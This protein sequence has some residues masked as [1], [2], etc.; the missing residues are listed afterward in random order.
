[1]VKSEFLGK[2]SVHKL[3]LSL[4]AF[5]V[6][7]MLATGGQLV[8][9]TLIVSRGIDIYAVSAIGIL[10]PLSMV[11]FAFSQL[12]AIGA[13]SYISRKLGERKQE[14]IF[15]AT[16][17]AFLMTLLISIGLM[18]LT[19]LAR[20]Q[21]LSFLGAEG[22]ALTFAGTYLNALIFSIPFTAIV[23]LLSA[24]FR[25][26]GK[27][28]YSMLVIVVEAVLIVILDAV[29]VFFFGW[30]IGWIAASIAIASSVATLLG[31]WLFIKASSN[32]VVISRKTMKLDLAAV[33]GILAVGVSA[34]GRSLAT[35]AFALIL[36]RAVRATGQE[37]ALAA[38]GTVNRIAL[39]LTFTVMGV[40]Q[41]MQPV[42]S[43]NFTSKQNVRV[44]RALKYALIYATLVGLA[45]SVMGIF[46]SNH[47]AEIFTTN[48][49]VV[50]DVAIV[51]R[52]QM[53][54]FATIGVQT[55]AATYYQS[56]GK[57]KASFFLSVAKPVAIL[58]PLVY[59][60][61]KLMNDNLT[62]VW[63]AFPIA[64]VIF[65]GIC[66]IALVKGMKSLG[67]TTG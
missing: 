36:N 20:E 65:T 58:I 17:T 31:I 59:L 55:L 32:K 14:E 33:K 12:V 57:A 38:L 35:A 27:M 11:Y 51:F 16:V 60:L 28:K 7:G 1:M 61:P 15:P 67:S 48:Q 42:V 41:A 2:E 29:F 22:E 50:D 40:N 3:M 63:W 54:L 53:I 21:I 25:A 10:H 44:R 46:L 4:G 18:G 9:T 34:L 19:W 26:Y 39:F 8:L 37:D 56:I 49:D 45:G 6:I 64:D 47:V 62:A 13:A 52:K 5:A 24:I 66:V 30:G 43:F 23:L